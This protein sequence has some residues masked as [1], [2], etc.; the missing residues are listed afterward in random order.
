V[1]G[2]SNHSRTFRVPTK[3][4]AK[5]RGTIIRV[6]STASARE[7]GLARSQDQDQ[8]GQTRSQEYDNASR[9]RAGTRC[10]DIFSLTSTRIGVTY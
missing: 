8:G 1:R 9:A 10:H 6:L 3:I 4:R 2:F 5:M 7:M